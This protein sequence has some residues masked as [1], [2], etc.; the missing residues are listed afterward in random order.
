MAK[1]ALVI[2]GGGAW[3]AFAVGALEYLVG[4]RGLT[5]DVLVGNSTGA[6]IAPLIAGEGAG[7]LDRLRREYTTVR[8]RDIVRPRV[9]NPLKLLPFS[10]WFYT[11]PLKKR[12]EDGV[13]EELFRRIESSGKQLLLSTV[14]L[15]TGQLVFFQMGPPVR[16]E[17][18]VVP[19]RTRAALVDAML[20]SSSIPFFMPL[21]RI[22]PG[23]GDPF[24]DGGVREF[25]PI[26]VAIEAGADEIVAIVLLPPAKAFPASS[27]HTR[28]LYH[29]ARTTIDLLSQEVADGDVKLSRLY[30]D[31]IRYLDAV[32]A[33]LRREL[34]AEAGRVDA[35]FADP[36]RPNPFAGKVPVTL[37]LVR[38]PRLL[39]DDA[40]KFDPAEMKA[41]LEF[42]KKIAREQLEG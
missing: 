32:R 7:A 15:R 17:H 23:A 30:T 19:L 14:N 16:S 18:E 25:A 12:I 13:S 24:G 6:L 41:N 1:R 9:T 10:S 20:A 27:G 8:T 22:P 40:L 37:H 42:G 31:G 36:G 2:S 26:E 3:G 21:V 4:E 11:D 38:T 39:G 28:D 5:F 34:P 29:V 35:A 33:R